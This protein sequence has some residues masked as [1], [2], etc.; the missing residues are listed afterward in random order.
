MNE[1]QRL[2]IDIT[3]YWTCNHGPCDECKQTFEINRCPDQFFEN[4]KDQHKQHDMRQVIRLVLEKLG[5][6]DIVNERIDP[7]IAADEIADVLNDLTK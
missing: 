1:L 2:W 3:R 4:P 7:E 5:E 6:K